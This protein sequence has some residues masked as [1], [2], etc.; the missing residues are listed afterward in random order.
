[1]EISTLAKE[2]ALDA[3]RSTNHYYSEKP[4]EFHL[5]MCQ[6]VFST[7]QHLV[8]GRSYDIWRASLWLHDT[9]EDCRVSYNDILNRFGFEVAEI[10]FAVTNEKGRTRADRENEKYFVGIRKVEGAT[11]VKLCDR[12]ANATY[13]RDSGNSLFAR[14]V[15]ENKAFEDY[16]YDYAYH[17]M[18][19]RLRLTLG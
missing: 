5:N 2:F 18:F 3:H 11:F 17:D 9:I 10:V 1:M 19:I 12:I 13:A 7:Y 8:P 6:S 16:L 15:K 4:Y 14:Y